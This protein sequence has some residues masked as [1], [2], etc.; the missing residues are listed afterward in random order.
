MSACN[1]NLCKWKCVL[2][3]N[4]LECFTPHCG[5]FDLHPCLLLC[6]HL[7]C[8][9]FFLVC[10]IPSSMTGAQNA[11]QSAT[12][13]ALNWASLHMPPY[14]PGKNLRGL[15]IS[16]SRLAGHR[17]MDKVDRNIEI[18]IYQLVNSP[19]LKLPEYASC[20]LSPSPGSPRTSHHPTTK[21]S[22]SGPTRMDSLSSSC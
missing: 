4:L 10:T 19:A 6:V 9:S 15:Y 2:Y 7:V 3:L 11:L 8:S 16:N 1:F 20:C 12:T 17:V 5:S 21:A 13:T 22:M 14:E 18:L